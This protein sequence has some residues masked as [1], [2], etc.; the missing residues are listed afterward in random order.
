M[1]QK[2]LQDEFV[3]RYNNRDLSLE[4]FFT[5]LLTNSINK[6]LKYKDLIC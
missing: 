3:F 2:H 1:S 4:D 6:I 5:C